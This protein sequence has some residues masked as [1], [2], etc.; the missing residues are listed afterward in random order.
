MQPIQLQKHSLP[1]NTTQTENI[2]EEKNMVLSQV[3]RLQRDLLSQTPSSSH[4]MLAAISLEVLE[5]RNFQQALGS[6]VR[7]SSTLGLLGGRRNQNTESASHIRLEQM[8]TE[9]LTG[10]LPDL[11]LTIQTLER[12]NLAL[13]NADPAEYPNPQV[14]QSAIQGNNARLATFRQEL[15]TIRHILNQR[16]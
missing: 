6:Q 16:R 9:D 12:D 2:S 8:T 4:N 11:Q 10:R 7:L 14:I 5:G 15:N 3:F 13:A 1:V